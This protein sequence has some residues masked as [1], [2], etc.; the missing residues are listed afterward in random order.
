MLFVIPYQPKNNVGDDGVHRT[1]SDIV[2][3]LT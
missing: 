2:I 1:T 3:I